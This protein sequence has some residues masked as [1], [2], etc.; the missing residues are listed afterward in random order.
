MP[1]I[2]IIDDDVSV[3]NSVEIALKAHGHAA[4]LFS[5]PKKF[6][7]TAALNDFDLLLVDNDMPKMTGLELHRLLKRNHLKLPI[8]VLMSGRI[9]EIE[10]IKLD[11]SRE[12]TLLIKPF[13]LAKLIQ[14]L[15]FKYFLRI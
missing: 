6:L 11:S 7:E 4:V 3:R 14:I 12:I 9:D 13:S 10:L 15:S 5:D 2:A 8:F 1:K